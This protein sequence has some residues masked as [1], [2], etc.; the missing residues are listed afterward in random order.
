MKSDLRQGAAPDGRAARCS[1]TCSTT[2][3]E[4]RRRAHAGGDRAPARARARRVPGRGGRMG[5]AGRAARHRPRGDD[6][7][8]RARAASTGTLLVVCGD[9]PLLRADDAARTAARG[10]RA[11]RRAVTVLVDAAARPDRLRPHRARTPD[12]RSIE[13]IVEERDA[14]PEQL[15][16]RRGQLRHLRVRLPDARDGAVRAH[17]AQRAGRVLPHRH[18]RAAARGGRAQGRGGAARRTTAS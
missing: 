16:D 2:L 7:R 18:G 3:D 10:T 6:G 13:R 15:R 12:G 17:A 4:L 14:T 1:A 8:A 11:S 9:T 5:G